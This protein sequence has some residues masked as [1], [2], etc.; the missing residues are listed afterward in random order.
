MS[1]M[2]EEQR[3]SQDDRR[4][5]HV[6]HRLYEITATSVA[7]GLFIGGFVFITLGALIPTTAE[8]HGTRLTEIAHHILRDL[9]IAAIISALL[10]SAYEY[11][12][13]GEF[14]K[15]AQTGLRDVLKE[16]REKLD[17][18][19]AA[20]LETIH[21][22][23]T[24]DLLEQNFLNV[25]RKAQRDLRGSTPP[26]R[27]RILETWTGFALE[28]IMGLVKE[29]ASVGCR[30]EILLLDPRS[31]QVAYRARAMHE[32]TRSIKGQIEDELQKLC[33]ISSELQESGN[34][35]LEVKVYDAAPTNHIY[36][37]D[38]TMIIGIYWRRLA[39]FMGPQFELVAQN[40]RSSGPHL[41]QLIN[42]QFDDLWER[43]KTH[44]TELLK[45]LEEEVD[46]QEQAHVFRVQLKA[47]DMNINRRIKN[48]RESLI[49][50]L[51]E[52]KGFEEA[53]VLG[54][55][56]MNSGMSITLWAS[57]ED[58]RAAFSDPEIEERF[59]EA[60]GVLATPPEQS[61]YDVLL[62]ERTRLSGP[63]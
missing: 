35:N 24:I 55:Y 44:A 28:G 36:D 33:R 43:S 23:L 4:M 29:A 47:G 9:G 46:R 27:I 37:F 54:D 25:M 26:P 63:T 48:W 11:V 57:E 41:V 40:E 38:G 2:N 39:S 21:D 18:F 31:P 22:E 56:D 6:Q 16:D 53:L 10:G 58:V 7:L 15:D 14:I 42:E 52:Q 32:G 61:T 30:V 19:R 1:E 8:E 50:K 59:T 34:P 49:P 13:R 5:A 51:K 62:R 12:L 60:A 45:I 17:R 20:G 3:S